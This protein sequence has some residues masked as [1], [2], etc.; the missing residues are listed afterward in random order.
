M[1]QP[2]RIYFLGGLGEIGR[3]CMVLEQD[4]K[5]MLIDCG[6]MFPDAD[7]HGIDL[8]LPD[9]TFLRENADRI[10][11]CVATHGHEDHVGGLQFLLRELSFPIYGSMVTL[12]LARNRIEE[13]GLLKKT[14]LITVRDGERIKIGP[15]D[16]EFLPVT[17]SVPHAH[18][19]II[20]TPQGVIV[21]SGDFKLDLTPVDD[22]RTD[23]A[24]L[25]ELSK[26]V[27]IRLLMCDSTNA[28]EHGHAPSE[29]SV[30]AVLHQLFHEHRDRRII[31][32]SFA[33]HIHRVQQI[34]E[35]AIDN[36]RKV[37]LMG[38][39]MQKNIGLAIDL[40]LINVPA[41]V[42]VD[43]EKV[44]DF[45]PEDI[46][47]I[48]TGSQGEPMAAL[49]L[50][51]RGESRWFKVGERDTIILS[52]HAIPGNE[53]NV[54]RVIDGLVRAGAKVV[55][56]GIADVHA[57]GHAQ[58]DEL[59]TYHSI[60]QPEWFVPVHGE[61]RHMR[62]HAELAVVM[63][64]APDHVLQATDGDVLELSDDGLAFHS[65]VPASYLFVDGIVG[66]V[67]HGVLRD[68]KVLAE[69]GVV[70]IVATVDSASHKVINGPE[71]ITRGW[72]YA[73]EADAL[74][75]EA[76]AHIE[77]A[78]VKALDDGITDIDGLERVVRKAAGKFV[79]DRTKR[80]PM[81]VPVVMT[82]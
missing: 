49:S 56:S 6:L 45:A 38:R 13:A 58:A 60:L 36:G 26:T 20:H 1:A 53:G 69:E 37:C 55:H 52:S 31:T 63:G 34:I 80:R 61:Y 79:S 71:V 14:D 30:G 39:S 21:H 5:L 67:G 57:T 75:D 81:I 35:A 59:K 72:V 51:S 2:V 24:R 12:G 29:K 64:A 43:V 7:M 48:S 3:N 46:C 23:L 77:K 73:P 40:K 11:G 4:D 76:E 74:L 28:E 32:A 27:G 54:N 50:L 22:R 42:F 41:S 78:L 19:V 62:A 16:V 68:R 47:I 66:D 18:A 33:S 25:G 44:D 65:T 15:F 82:T 70:V 17:H 10:V 8:V 9:F